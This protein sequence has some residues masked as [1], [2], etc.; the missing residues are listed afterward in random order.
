IKRQ[1]LRD[2]AG[3]NLASKIARLRRALLV[4]HSPSDTT[5][6]I[7]NA[8]RILTAAKHPKSFVGLE[9]ADQPLRQRA[10][11]GFAA[12]VTA[13]VG[14]TLCRDCNVLAWPGHAR[15]KPGS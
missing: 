10:D 12:Q 6:D 2:V 8:T 11:A 4:I 7:A 14:R 3:Q 15:S 1:F 5:V 13:P 9:H